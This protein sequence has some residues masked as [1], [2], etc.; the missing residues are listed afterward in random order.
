MPTLK[1][2]QATQKINISGL[3]L[4]CITINKTPSSAVYFKDEQLD[5]K[6]ISNTY[7][8]LLPAGT[9]NWLEIA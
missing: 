1:T 4:F 5:V 2:Q 3:L 6:A 7:A 9:G 8:H